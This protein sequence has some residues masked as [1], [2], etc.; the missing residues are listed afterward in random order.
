M[1]YSILRRSNPTV[2]DRYRSKIINAPDSDWPW[3]T[4]GLML[5]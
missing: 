1:P 2:F 5:F 4:G 3:R